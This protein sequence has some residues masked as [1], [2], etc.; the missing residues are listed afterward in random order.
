MA[1]AVRFD[2]IADA[3]RFNRGFKDAERSSVRFSTTLARFGSTSVRAIGGVGVALAGVAAAGAIT[4]VKTAASLEQAEIGFTQLLGSGRKAQ[5][6]MSQLSAFAAK[7]P[8]ELPGLIDAARGL[9]GAGTAAKD[10]IPIMTALGDASGALGLD[11]ER[12]GR[13]MLAVTQIMNKGKVQAEELMQ[14]TEAGIPVWPLLSKA[15]HKSVP[16]LQKLQ[17]QGKLLSKDVLPVLFDQMHKDYGGSMAK[18]SQTLAGLWSTFKDTLNIGLATAIKP[19]EAELKGGVTAA[20]SVAGKALGWIGGR[21]TWLAPKLSLAATGAHAL[22]AAFSGE[23]ITSTGFVGL[24]ER[25]GVTARSVSDGI[26]TLVER[27]GGLQNVID[28]VV[29]SFGALTVLR[30]GAMFGPWGLAI[31]AVAGA[32]LLLGDRSSSLRQSLSQLWQ[33]IAQR[34]APIFTALAGLIQ[35]YVVPQLG[36]LKSAWDDNRKAIMGLLSGPVAMALKILGVTLVIAL[37]VLVRGVTSLITIIGGLARAFN[38]L[39]SHVI[40]P[41]TKFIL[42]AFLVMVSGIVTG[43]AKAFGWVPGLGPKLRQAAKTVGK[44]KDDTNRLLD[45]IDPVKNIKVKAS[46]SL[47]FTKSFTQKDWVDVRLA[48]V[49]MASGGKLRGPGTGT[50]DSIPLWGSKGEF[51]VN[52]KSTNK[53]LPVLKWINADRRAAGGP[54]S[55]IDSEARAVNKLEAWGTGQ[56]MERGIN[57]LMSMFGG[58]IKGFLRLADRL[59]YIWGGVGPGGYDCSGITGEVLNR[60]QHRP[61]YHRRFTTASN[62]RALG[63]KPG[64]GGVYTIGVD[65][66]RGHMVGRYAG[67]GFEAESTRTGIKVGSA[68]SSVSSFPAQYHMAKGGLVGSLADW[69][70][71]QRGIAVGGDPARLRVERFDHGGMLLPGH[72]GYNGTGRSEPVGL[73]EDRLAAKIAAAL[74]RALREEPPRVA[75]DD[76]HTG[77]I[78][79]KNGRMGGMSLGLS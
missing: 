23:G 57:K 41:V 12:F 59:P 63:F 30:I 17:Q 65:A 8:F 19:F 39:W 7:T 26:K 42:N 32:V 47:N 52:A 55:A 24:M 10:V 13:V 70:S 51:M 22:G 68:A 18:Q 15:M 35:K 67:L 25:V 31:G 56:R 5:K 49:R 53:W 48:A 79:K 43:A 62:F 6:F 76:I 1:K 44:F 38:W 14:I 71:R 34:V 50:S 54:I 46:L 29:R 73:D 36:G 72:L 40:A 61:S 27:L 20:I 77:L 75:V 9:I 45:Q 2:L 4:G 16:E 37:N 33:W 60:M 66:G 11:Q 74:V 3:T 58:G 78:R 64:P 28:G 69:L 21:A